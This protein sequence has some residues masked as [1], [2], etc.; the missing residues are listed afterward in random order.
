[1]W[2]YVEVC[3]DIGVVVMVFQYFACCFAQLAMNARLA[4]FQMNSGDA[5]VLAGCFG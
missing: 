2:D 1:M 5:T 4:T 3:K